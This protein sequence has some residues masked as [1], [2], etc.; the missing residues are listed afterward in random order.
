MDRK[1]LRGIRRTSSRTHLCC[2]DPGNREPQATR[3]SQ[4]PDLNSLLDVRYQTR[5]A[6]DPY[7]RARNLPTGRSK[8]CFHDGPQS[9]CL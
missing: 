9:I 6:G 3:P 8:L 7:G 1:V 2:Q 5:I 4:R